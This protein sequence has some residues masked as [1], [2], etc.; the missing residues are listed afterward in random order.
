MFVVKKK[1]AEIKINLYQ[2]HELKS[3]NIKYLLITTIEKKIRIK[4]QVSIVFVLF[5]LDISVVIVFLFCIQ[6]LKKFNLIIINLNHKTIC[7]YVDLILEEGKIL[8][9]HTYS[10]SF[11]VY[12]FLCQ[13]QNQ[14]ILIKIHQKIKSCI[15]GSHII[16]TLKFKLN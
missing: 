6:Y 2:T 14:V 12:F 1:H 13:M 9:L 10:S 16:E 15:F 11:F 5:L 7:Q 3:N 8:H 4:Y